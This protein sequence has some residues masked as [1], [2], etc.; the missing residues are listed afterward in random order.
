MKR[1]GYMLIAAL[2]L[3][4]V[5]ILL[6]TSAPAAQPVGASE[7]A[8]ELAEPTE[9]AS[10]R[11]PELY[12]SAQSSTDSA[13]NYIISQLETASEEIA[14]YEHGYRVSVSELSD[15]MLEIIYERPDIF[16]LSREYGYSYT[17][18][19]SVYVLKPAYT[20]TGTALS[21]ARTEYEQMIAKLTAMASKDWSELETA[22]FYHDYIVSN[23]AYDSATLSI[24]DA[25]GMLKQKSGVCQAYTLLYADILNRLGINNTAAVSNTMSHVWSVIEIDGAWYH[26]DLTWDDP[27]VN[28]S[29][30]KGR[31]Y[32]NN[33]LCSP[34]AIAATGHSDWVY[35]DRKEHSFSSKYDN[36]FFKELVRPTHVH[37][38]GIYYLDEADSYIKRYDT[39]TNTATAL[40]YID[41]TAYVHGENTSYTKVQSGFCGYGGKLYYS[42]QQKNSGCVFIYEYDIGTAKTNLLYTIECAAGSAQSVYGMYSDGE[43]ICYLFADSP[44]DL[45]SGTLYSFKVQ[46]QTQEQSGLLMDTDGDG[47]ITNCDLALL[48]RFLSGWKDTGIELRNADINGDSSITEAD[49]LAL[50]RSLAR[51]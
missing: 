38:T 6:P 17:S 46:V 22:L 37:S 40:F 47:K 23:F 42:A 21:E 11:L 39:E 29:D 49:A 43:T 15:L 5:T 51:A 10:A 3:S 26:A 48:L 14:V 44:N 7:A 41:S 35:A 12:L 19:G 34:D 16:Y 50:A 2:L 33:F 32:H 9:E 24:A 30:I 36:A 13:K 8:A 25:Y 1:N 28:G 31:V 4:A 27:L 20:H 45:A 18:D